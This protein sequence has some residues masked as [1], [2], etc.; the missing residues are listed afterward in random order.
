MLRERGGRLV[1]DGLRNTQVDV[2][3]THLEGGILLP[4]KPLQLSMVRSDETRAAHDR[5]NG[6]TSV[7]PL[8]VHR[9]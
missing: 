8:T 9:V 3:H 2:N 4:I 7:P 6:K 1:S 5:K